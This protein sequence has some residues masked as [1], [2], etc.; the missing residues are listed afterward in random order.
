[1]PNQSSVHHLENLLFFT[2]LQLIVII[3]TAR[4]ANVAARKLKQP[5]AVGEMM[6]GLILGPS[7]LG[8]MYPEAFTWLF[9][10]VSAE[11]I[12]ILSQIGLTLLMFQIGMDFEFKHLKSTANRR[13]LA[14][15]SIGSIVLP[16]GLG[17]WL[18]D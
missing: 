11:P 10:S 15:I 16:F 12:T 7:L 17:F 5:G 14:G 18:G 4:L 9:K 8:A 13:A 6:A 2:L 1:M 3:V